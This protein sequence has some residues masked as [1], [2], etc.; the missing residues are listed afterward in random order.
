MTMGLFPSKKKLLN[1]QT[2]PASSLK[3][4]VSPQ[5]FESGDIELE[6]SSL[7]EQQYTPQQPSQVYREP[8][9]QP[10]AQPVMARQPGPRT[11]PL[12][13]Q[14][15]QAPQP[16]YQEPQVDMAAIEAYILNLENRI[17]L[18]ESKLF[19]AGVV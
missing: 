3:S 14:Q 1:E 8:I 10:K 19:R 18:I 9:Q 2:N 4:S 17:A 7:G 13:P 12:Q 5:D 11:L 16:V 6:D 15:F